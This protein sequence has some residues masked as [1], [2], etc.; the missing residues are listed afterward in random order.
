MTKAEFLTRLEAAL[1]TMP[2]HERE[3][4]LYYY[5][6]YIDDAGPENEEAILDRLGSPERVAEKLL[7]DSDVRIRRTRVLSRPWAVVLAIL[8]APIAIPLIAAGFAVFLALLLV[9]FCLVLVALI[10]AFL[11]GLVL[12]MCFVGGLFGLGLGVWAIFSYLATGLYYIGSGL[13]MIG[14]GGIIFAA[15][16]AVPGKIVRSLPVVAGWF[17]RVL[18]WPFKRRKRL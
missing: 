15:Y 1:G 2:R 16:R 17:K 18:T 5:T 12:V 7:A 14:L 9:L 3:N 6:E 8:A 10:V 13:A 4:A 11:P